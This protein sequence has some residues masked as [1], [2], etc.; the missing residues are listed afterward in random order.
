L[1]ALVLTLG[2]V[3]GLPACLPVQRRFFNTI[4]SA[5]APSLTENKQILS[6]LSDIC[7]AYTDSGKY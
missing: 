7:F 3:A 2:Q 4:S 1:L 6:L 5:S